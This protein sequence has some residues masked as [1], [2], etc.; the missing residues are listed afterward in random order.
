[1]GS[2]IFGSRAHKK[3]E[4]TKAVFAILVLEASIAGCGVSFIRKKE[5][6]SA[7]LSDAMGRLRGILH[8]RS[9]RTTRYNIYLLMVWHVYTILYVSATHGTKQRTVV[10]SR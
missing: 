2:A 10:L 9:L 1:M 4:K 8:A 6:R 3:N 7:Y 5:A